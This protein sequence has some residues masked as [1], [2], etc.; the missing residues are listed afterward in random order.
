MGKCWLPLARRVAAN[1][2]T[3]SRREGFAPASHDRFSRLNRR[4]DATVARLAHP[5]THEVGSNLLQHLLPFGPQ[6]L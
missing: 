6:R 3:L 2:R 4:W 5:A 1:F